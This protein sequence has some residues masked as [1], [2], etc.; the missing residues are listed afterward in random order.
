MSVVCWLGRL[1]LCYFLDIILIKV[2]VTHFSY[3]YPCDLCGLRFCVCVFFYDFG[4][5][6]HLNFLG[7][8]GQCF[9]FFVF[10]SRLILIIA[11]V[12]LPF[13]IAMS[14]V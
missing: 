7:Y 14:S 13:I 2:R 4:V 9:F 12:I 3:L 10:F 11:P 5:Y 1:G 6:S 8:V